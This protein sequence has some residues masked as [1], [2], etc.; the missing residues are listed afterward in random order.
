M[1]RRRV[2]VG[3]LGR[4]LLGLM[5]VLGKE[6]DAMMEREEGGGGDNILG[7]GL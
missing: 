2:L 4:E 7:C 3:W 1:I 6:K 5:G